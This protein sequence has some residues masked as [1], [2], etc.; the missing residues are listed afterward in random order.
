MMPFRV[1]LMPA[2]LVEA[3]FTGPNWVFEEKGGGVRILA[4]KE[5]HP[6]SACFAERYRPHGPLSQGRGGG[7][8]TALRVT[9]FGWEVVVCDTRHV[10]FTEWTK[11]EKLRHFVFPG[12]RGDKKPIEVVRQEA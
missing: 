3:P 7:S 6:G 11:V 8:E 12:L 5:G 9:P 4:Y 10:S 1:S 2:A